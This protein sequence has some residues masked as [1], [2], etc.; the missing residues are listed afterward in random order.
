LRA[1]NFRQSAEASGAEE[2]IPTIKPD[3]EAISP[4]ALLHTVRH[5]SP[6][7]HVGMVEPCHR[8]LP[9][10]A[11][12]WAAACL[13]LVLSAGCHSGRYRASA[14]P[15]ELQAPPLAA[16]RT[17][18]LTS[19][20]QTRPNTEQIFAGDV[21]EVGIST[22]LERQNAN[23][24]K[25]RVG[26][27]GVIAVPLVGPV[28]VAGKMLPDAEYAVHNASV[29]RGIYRN[30]Q[31]TVQLAERRSIRVSVVGEVTRPGDYNLPLVQADLLAAI[32]MAGGLKGDSAGDLIEISY[33]PN[34][35]AVQQA[36]YPGGPPSPVAGRNVTIDLREVSQRQPDIHL[37]NGSVVNVS[38]KPARTFT[39]QGLVKKPGR[40]DGLNDQD[41]RLLDALA[42]AGGRTMEIADRVLIFRTVEGSDQP[43]VITASV[44]EAKEG[45]PGNL[46]IAPGDIVSVEET[47]VTFALGTI[48]RFARL[49]FSA[50]VPLF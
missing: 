50:A 13:T 22:G 44:N 48:S 3:G 19:L 16:S 46:L 4:A 32:A 38:R 6:N 17:P 10:P 5:A 2:P 8:R 26:D 28:Q 27:D 37:E 35:Y 41:I 31:V 25:L 20:G 9:R 12:L 23:R 21:L 39:V 49:G 45:G 18:D 40:Y 34:P 33:P 43:V 14:L 36:S 29:E 7:K 30:P 15:P 11:C 1:A 42:I 47:P 24:W